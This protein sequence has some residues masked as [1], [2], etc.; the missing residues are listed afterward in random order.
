MNIMNSNKIIYQTKKDVSKCSCKT[1][2]CKPV[3]KLNALDLICS[4][5]NSGSLMQGAIQ[6]LEADVRFF[7]F[8]DKH[9]KPFEKHEKRFGIPAWYKMRKAISC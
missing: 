6:N 8:D 2:N 7:N 1:Y 4:L 3:D 5:E 9:E